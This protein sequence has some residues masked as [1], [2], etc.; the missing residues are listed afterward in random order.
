MTDVVVNAN[1]DVD[2][3]VCVDVD[4]VWGEV[5]AFNACCVFWNVSAYKYIDNCYEEQIAQM[6]TSSCADDV[7]VEDN[8]PVLE[9]GRR[10]FNIGSPATPQL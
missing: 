4:H 8:V 7:D 3:G 6:T 10:L 9:L 1:V 5:S 2:A